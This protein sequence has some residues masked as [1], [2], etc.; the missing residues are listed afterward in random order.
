LP[1]FIETIPLL[2][3][4]IESYKSEF[5]AKLFT[6]NYWN[7]CV[8]VIKSYPIKFLFTSNTASFFFVTFKSH[9]TM[10]AVAL[11]NCI[12][13][14]L[15][16]NIFNTNPFANPSKACYLF[17]GPPIVFKNVTFPYNIHYR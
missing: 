6:L 3:K 9:L 8:W 14:L 15:S 17:G 4:A 11:Y 10:A 2:S 5:H 16:T 1:V 7:I 13:K 12:G